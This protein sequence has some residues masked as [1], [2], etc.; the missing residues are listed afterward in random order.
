[1]VLAAV[2]LVVSD[3]LHV[4]AAERAQFMDWVKGEFV[5]AYGHVLVF[6]S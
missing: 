1:M 6:R 4:E 5:N 3:F 2:D